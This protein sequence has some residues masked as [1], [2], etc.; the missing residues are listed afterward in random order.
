MTPLI[1]SQSHKKFLYGQ[2]ILIHIHQPTFTLIL[3]ICESIYTIL[4]CSTTCFLLFRLVGGGGYKRHKLISSIPYTYLADDVVKE[5]K[6]KG[7]SRHEQ[8][9]FFNLAAVF[10]EQTYFELS[11]SVFNTICAKTTSAQHQKKLFT[12]T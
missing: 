4:L 3:I 5:Q 10:F 1:Q 6:Q 2:L 9:C 12:N 7:L 8:K 11:S